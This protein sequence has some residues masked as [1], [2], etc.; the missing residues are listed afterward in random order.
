[1]RDDLSR[2][3]MAIQLTCQMPDNRKD[4]ETILRRLREH[5]MEYYAGPAEGEP[6]DNVTPLRLVE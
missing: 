2:R 5:L 6:Q 3:R 4:C 1:M